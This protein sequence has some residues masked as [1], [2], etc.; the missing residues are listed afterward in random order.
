MVR[1]RANR[2]WRRPFSVYANTYNCTHTYTR[3]THNFI[4]TSYHW[5][6]ILNV[7]RIIRIRRFRSVTTAL[8]DREVFLVSPTSRPCTRHYNKIS[9]SFSVRYN[10]LRR[11]RW[12][13]FWYFI[14]AMCLE[15][16]S[17]T[18]IL[19][20]ARVV[21]III[22]GSLAAVRPRAKECDLKNSR[23]LSASF[24]HHPSTL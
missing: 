19:S 17:Y 15:V 8:Y 22:I 14:D 10:P 23:T 11:L 1:V 16:C 7:H 9:L 4:S 3:L 21:R 18:A 6:G 12:R 5:I 13:W 20:C 2:A 24:T